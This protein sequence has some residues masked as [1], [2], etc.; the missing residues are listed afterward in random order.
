[1]AAAALDHSECIEILASKGADVN[2]P[3]MV[4]IL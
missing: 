2:K 3:D 1:M 4:R